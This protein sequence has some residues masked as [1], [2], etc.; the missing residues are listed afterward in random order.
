[1]Y[2]AGKREIINSNFIATLET[3]ELFL[4]LTKNFDRYENNDMT[5]VI[6]ALTYI[7]DVIGRSYSKCFILK[8]R[9]VY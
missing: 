5:K 1:M 8:S 4:L 3:V 6:M 7:V 2:R 9:R